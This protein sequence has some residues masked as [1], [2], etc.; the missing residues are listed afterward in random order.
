[1]K[2]AKKGP[3]WWIWKRWPSGIRNIS[4]S[5]PVVLLNVPDSS[6]LL[7]SGD[8]VISDPHR[9]L[10]APRLKQL[11]RLLREKFD[12]VLIDTPPAGMLS[13]AAILSRYADAVLYVVRQDLASTTQILDAIQGMDA[14]GADIIGC[15]LNRTQAGTTRSGYASRYSSYNYGYKHS[16]GYSKKQPR[17]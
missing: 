10:D 7:I 15:V 3:S 11:I 12:Y 13:D 6:L 2:Q 9:L 5:T 4:S 1:M 8:G 14:A 16:Y 17:E